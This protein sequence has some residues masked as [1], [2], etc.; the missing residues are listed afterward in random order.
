MLWG[1]DCV[2]PSPPTPPPPPQHKKS[3]YNFATLGNY[4][5]V[6]FQQVTFKFGNCINLKVLISGESTDFS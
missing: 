6:R 5:F 4:I 3:H 2:P 1:Q